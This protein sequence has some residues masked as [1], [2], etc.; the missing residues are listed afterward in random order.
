MEHAGGGSQGHRVP[1]R[2]HGGSQEGT[3][4]GPDHRLARSV[5]PHHAAG[6]DSAGHRYVEFDKSDN[7]QI[8]VTYIPFQPWAHGPTLR[9]QKHADTGRMMP[10]PEFPADKA[11]EMIRAIR[12]ALPR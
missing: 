5:E 12:E 1:V 6:T 4:A 7:E 11:E 9:V 10:S 3:Y 8:R 2:E